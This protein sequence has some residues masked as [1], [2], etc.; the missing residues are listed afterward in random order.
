MKQRSHQGTIGEINDNNVHRKLKIQKENNSLLLGRGGDTRISLNSK[1]GEEKKGPLR[2][3]KNTN[4]VNIKSKVTKNVTEKD[5]LKRDVPI[6]NVQEVKK[7]EMLEDKMVKMRND[8][9]DELMKRLEKNFNEKQLE[10]GEGLESNEM[11]V[12]KVTKTKLKSNLGV[13]EVKEKVEMKENV[14]KVEKLDDNEKSD[15]R[16]KEIMEKRKKA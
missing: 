11:E 2:V 4:N 6:R 10:E 5:F 9:I 7:D 14:K 13:K 16:K 1:G 12:N 8:S 3:I 15:I